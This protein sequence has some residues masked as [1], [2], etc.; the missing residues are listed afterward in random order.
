MRASRRMA[1]DRGRRRKRFGAL[2]GART[3]STST[4]RRANCWRCWALG[5]G[6]DDAAARHRRART[7]RRAAQVSSTARTR[8]TITVAGAPRRLRVPALRAVPAHDRVRE[9]RL[10]PRV[11]ARAERARR[12][13]EIAAA[14]RRSC[15][16]WCSSTGFAERYPGATVRRP[17]PARGARPRARHRAARAAARRAVRRARRQ[18]AQGTAPL[19]ARISRPDRP[20]DGLRHPRPGRGDGARRS[21]R[22]DEP[23]RIEQV[24]APEEIY[25]DPAAPRS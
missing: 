20:H 9:H 2:S 4:S 15:W 19:A 14:R 25:D 10:R 6:Q 21:R 8:S 23:G 12:E 17:A 22:G 5:L 1:F 13:A 7:S 16:T 24:G 18:G 3:A 11:R